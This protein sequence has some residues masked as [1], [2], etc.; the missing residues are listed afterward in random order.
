M[1]AAPFRPTDELFIDPTS[2]ARLRVYLDPTTGE[3][4]YYAE[5]DRPA[6]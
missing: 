6:R 5:E 1:P 2:G 4:R 3:R